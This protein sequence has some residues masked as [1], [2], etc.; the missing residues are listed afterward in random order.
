MTVKSGKYII[1]IDGHSAC[2]KSTI[3]KSLAEKLGFIYI[4]SGAM[5]RAVTY[6]CLQEGIIEK[7]EI[8]QLLLE[9]KIDDIKIEF[10]K[11][12]ENKMYQTFLNGE[13]V[14]EEIRKI[15][16]SQHVSQVSKI[17]K[18]RDKMVDLQRSMA[19]NNSIIMDGR[20][21]GTVVFPNAN[22]KI[23]MTAELKIRAKRRYKELLEK[24]QNISLHEIEKNIIERDEI[25]QSREI[26]PLKKAD[27][28]VVLDNS[29]LTQQEQLDWAINEVDKLLTRT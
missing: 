22:L 28:A 23:F 17:K 13:N 8:N 24:G 16:V 27:D 6:Y 29:Y 1:A 12:T 20:D 5:Y 26:S 10:L 11:L 15:K 9:E 4:D 21:I 7:N 3:A 18:V 2:G 19:E 25:D 14:E